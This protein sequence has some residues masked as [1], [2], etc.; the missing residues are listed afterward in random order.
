MPLEATWMDLEIY[1]TE[2][3]KSGRERQI[4]CDI[5]SMWNLIKMIQNNLLNK[6]KQTH[7]FQDPSY[8]YHRGKH[9]EKE[10]IARVGITH[11]QYFIKWMINE[12][13]LCS[14]VK[15]TQ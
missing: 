1:H 4:S 9:W 11:T 13:M 15:P 5:T 7:R 8:G 12:N 14:T 3:S 2:R 10:R 6:Q